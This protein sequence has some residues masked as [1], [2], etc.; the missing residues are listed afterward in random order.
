VATKGYTNKQRV[1]NVLQRP[2]SDEETTAVM[3]LIPGVEAFID[4]YTR[5]SWLVISPVNRELRRIFDKSNPVVYLQNV[6][7]IGVTRIVDE[8][9]P[10]NDVWTP[11]SSSLPSD[12]FGDYTFIDLPTGWLH[13]NRV[14]INGHVWV[15]YTINAATIP[16]DVHL[17]AT[18]LVLWIMDLDKLGAKQ[19][20]LGQDVTQVLADRKDGFPDEIMHLLRAVRGPVGLAFA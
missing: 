10:P 9:T 2:L 20:V 4:Q 19:T 11:P 13:L 14:P 15:D 12:R 3:E 5:Q 8:S 18:L 17:A 1:R 16:G 7:V 6:P